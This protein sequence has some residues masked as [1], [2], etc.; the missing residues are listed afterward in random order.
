MSRKY[1]SELLKYLIQ[2]GLKIET[3]FPAPFDAFVPSAWEQLGEDGQRTLAI[4][5]GRAFKELFGEAIDMA[6][7]ARMQGRSINIGTGFEWFEDLMRDLLAKILDNPTKYKPKLITTI[8][9]AA[10]ESA[11]NQTLAARDW[12]PQSA[13]SPLPTVGHPSQASR[14]NTSSYSRPTN[15]PSRSYV[16]APPPHASPRPTQPL[17]LTL[18]WKYIGAPQDVPEPHTD[19]AV[20]SLESKGC[21][22]FGARVRGLSHKHEGI[23]CDD[24]FEIST[25]GDW[26]IITVADGAGSKKFSRVGARIACETAVMEL[27][28]SLM[29]L[30]LNVRQTEED[31]RSVAERVHEA[32]PFVESDVETAAATVRAAFIS[33]H[34]A[35]R[36]KAKELANIVDY[37]VI[38][39][40][41]LTV[42]DLSCTLNIAVHCS[43]QEQSVIIACQIGDGLIGIVQPAGDSRVLSA[44]DSGGYAGE[45]EFLTSASTIEQSSILARTDVFAGSIRALLV[46]TDGVSNDFF[47]E[48][49]SPTRLWAELLVNGI[50]DTNDVFTNEHDTLVE[51]EKYAKKHEVVEKGPRTSVTIR[52]AAAYAKTLGITEADLAAKTKLAWFAHMGNIIKGEPVAQN[53]TEE[54]RLRL[55]LDG[56][57]KKGGSKDDR[58]LVVL[59]RES[60]P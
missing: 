8:E 9:K 20:D 2:Y 29:S 52:S 13:T 7:I 36:E 40:R 25:S 49:G 16:P 22:A 6:V 44:A 53:E 41:R 60:K 14:S 55:W 48:K 1:D 28:A 15:I 18:Q 57:Y 19:F 30:R 42:D 33:A 43:F 24:W 23:H 37:E 54:K 45:T 47:P 21:R 12:S 3:T 5:A 26:T 32:G 34:R 27:K 10:R 51:L 4:Q 31:W 46:M 17:P 59:Y 58:T 56:F 50:P 38:L 11:N 39:G 35:L